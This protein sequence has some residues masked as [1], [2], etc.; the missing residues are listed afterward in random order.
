[1]AKKNNTIGGLVSKGLSKVN[2][3]VAICLFILFVLLNNNIFIENILARV[4]GAVEYDVPT[5]YGT[6]IQG[7]LLIIGFMIMD[8]F[9]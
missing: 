7:L 8:I 6:M 4:N 1:M 9:L 2:Y 5:S 3:M